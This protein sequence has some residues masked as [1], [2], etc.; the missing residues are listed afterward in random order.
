M[1]T[2]NTWFDPESDWRYRREMES[3]QAEA[4]LSGLLI[5]LAEKMIAAKA[6]GRCTKCWGKGGTLPN[7]I[8][9]CNC[10]V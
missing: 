7:G 2:R 9:Y 6:E 10:E 3:E 4:A 5:Q 8:P 1:T